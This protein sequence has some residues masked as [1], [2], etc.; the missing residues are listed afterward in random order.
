MEKKY[1]DFVDKEGKET[2]AEIVLC[3]TIEG[4][5]VVIYTF[6]EKDENG[7]VIL[8]ASVV[9]NENDQVRFEKIPAEDWADVKVIMNKIVKEWSE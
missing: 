4:K 1:I 5:K 7:M 3:F 2:R 6:N 9:I 8:Y